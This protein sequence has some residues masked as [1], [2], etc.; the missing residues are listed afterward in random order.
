M[1]NSLI[2]IHQ[3]MVPMFVRDLVPTVFS[4]KQSL[5]GGAHDI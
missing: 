1:E 4:P 3:G 2:I 5:G